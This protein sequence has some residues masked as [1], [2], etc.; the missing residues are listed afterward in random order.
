MMA[1]TWSHDSS[2]KLPLPAK[3]KEPVDRSVVAHDYYGLVCSLRL[4]SFRS[5]TSGNSCLPE[6]LRV[7]ILHY[8]NL[9]Q[10]VFV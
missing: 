9:N 5:A 10:S 2:Q 6:I 4:L 7:Y 8:C 1:K 3:P